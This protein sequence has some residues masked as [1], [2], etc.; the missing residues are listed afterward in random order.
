MTYNSFY[1]MFNTN[2]SLLQYLYFFFFVNIGNAERN[3]EAKWFLFSIIARLHNG[4]I[5]GYVF[6]RPALPTTCFVFLTMADL[7]TSSDA[8][9]IIAR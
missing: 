1:V 8:S 3:Q 6:V 5:Y 7:E 4:A 9:T 2:L